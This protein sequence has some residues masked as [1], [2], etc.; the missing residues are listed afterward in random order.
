[1]S[2]IGGAALLALAGIILVTQMVRILGRAALG[3][4]DNEAVLPFIAFGLLNYLPVL[5]SLA[6]F[7]GVFLTL[8]RIWQDSEMVVWQ[9]A[10]L[11]PLSWLVPVLRFAIP[12]AFII[13]ALSLVVSPWVAQKRAEYKQLLSVRD[14]SHSLIPGVFIESGDGNRVFFVEGISKQDG[15][16]ENIFIQS[17]QNGRHGVIVARGGHVASAENGDRFLTLTSGRRY[18]GAPG[19]ADYRMM[20]FE[21]Y[22]VRLEPSVIEAYADSPRATRTTDLLGNSSPA[23]RAEWVWRLGYPISALLLAIFAIPASHLNPRAGRSL[24]VI[25]AMLV[26][27]AYYNLIGLSEAWVSQQTLSATASMLLVHGSMA[28]LLAWLFWRQTRGFPRGAR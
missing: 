16:V 13:A 27:T 23:Y 12:G 26:Y 21:R 19:S 8:S 22:A 3:D 9:G 28:G 6:L 11:G 18:E 1:M 20:E 25:F 10:G 7:L 2:V 15:V 14:E 24:N 5:L 4:V 17:V